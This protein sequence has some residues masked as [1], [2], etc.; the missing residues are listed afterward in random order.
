MKARIY[1]WDVEEEPSP[2][3]IQVTRLGLG[4][5]KTSEEQGNR[6]GRGTGRAVN[7]TK[8]KTETNQSDWLVV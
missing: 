6:G 5:M 8:T 7:T 1:Y 4:G 2:E 3:G